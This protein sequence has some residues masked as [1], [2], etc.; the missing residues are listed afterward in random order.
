MHFKFFFAVNT[1][2]EK[3]IFKPNFALLSSFQV[4]FERVINGLGGQI[5]YC[6]SI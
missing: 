6:L 4:K 1:S 2:M 5:S 3:L